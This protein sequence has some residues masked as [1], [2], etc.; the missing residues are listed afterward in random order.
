MLSA[1]SIQRRLWLRRVWT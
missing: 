1:C